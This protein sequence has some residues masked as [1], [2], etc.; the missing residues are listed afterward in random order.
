MH[1]IVT[2]IDIN[3][4]VV[5]CILLKLFW[6]IILKSSMPPQVSEKTSP[7]YNFRTNELNCY[8]LKAKKGSK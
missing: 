1:G 7:S 6:W 3:F 4:I 8:S 2:G 5:N